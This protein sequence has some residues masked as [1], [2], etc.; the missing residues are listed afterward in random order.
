MFTV[1]RI[2]NLINYRLYFGWTKKTIEARWNKHVNLAR[3]G[4]FHLHNAIRKWGEDC[5]TI[6]VESV[7]STEEEAKAEEIRLIA[8][9]DTYYNRNNGYNATKG[10]DISSGMLGK[11]HTEDAKKRISIGCKNR[12][13]EVVRNISAKNTG[14]KRT[15]EQKQRMRD[16]WTIQKRQEVSKMFKGIPKSPEHNA[17]VSAALTGKPLSPEHKE[18]CRLNRLGKKDTPEQNENRKKVS[19]LNWARVRAN[20][21]LPQETSLSQFSIGPRV[22]A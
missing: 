17:K 14:K 12:P 8:Y 18:K 13:V 15:S 7:W 2:T 21:R 16:C 1:Y 9:W 19:R 5:F 22:P 11:T 10:G 3:T 4:G 20:Y 6:T